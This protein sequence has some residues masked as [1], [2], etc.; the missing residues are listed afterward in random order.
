MAPRDTNSA[1]API[2]IAN[3]VGDFEVTDEQEV[4]GNGGWYPPKGV[5]LRVS[6]VSAEQARIEILTGNNPPYAARHAV[7]A[8]KYHLIGHR[9]IA[10]M[11]LQPGADEPPDPPPLI[12]TEILTM[13]AN[14][15]MRH[16]LSFNDGSLGYWICRPV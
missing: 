8:A 2:T 15:E 4:D 6:A 9:L 11:V 10:V 7:E 13:R 16:S 14:G 5:V 3:F 1:T 12:L